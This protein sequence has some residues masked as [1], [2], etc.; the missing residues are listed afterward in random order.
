MC[1]RHVQ[2][3]VHI[4]RESH[5][6]IFDC[7]GCKVWAHQKCIHGSLNRHWRICLQCVFIWWVGGI[8]QLW[9]DYY[10]TRIEVSVVRKFFFFQ[11]LFSKKILGYWNSFRGEGE[12]GETNIFCLLHFRKMFQGSWNAK[13]GDLRGLVRTTPI[14]GS[15]WVKNDNLFLWP[16]TGGKFGTIRFGVQKL[17]SG[18]LGGKRKKGMKKNLTKS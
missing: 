7:R 4:D 16:M 9:L 13:R 15:P 6:V 14:M 5:Y 1:T 8:S 12:G 11:N 3:P 18:N 10:C 17:L 2:Y